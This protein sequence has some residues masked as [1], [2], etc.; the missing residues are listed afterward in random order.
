MGA[1]RRHMIHP[2]QGKQSVDL[3]LPGHL[4]AVGGDAPQ[5]HQW[6]HGGVKG[7]A[8]GLTESQGGGD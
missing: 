2:H 4:G 3:L 8:G 1:V 5:G 6:G 7:P